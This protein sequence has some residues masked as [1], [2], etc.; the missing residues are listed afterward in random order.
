MMR[1]KSGSTTLV[2]EDL[3]F[4]VCNGYIRICYLRKK[5]PALEG[6]FL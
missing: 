6:L 5:A 3:S 1:K 2:N 4:A